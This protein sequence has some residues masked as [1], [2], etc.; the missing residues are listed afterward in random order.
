MQTR[1]AIQLSLLRALVIASGLLGSL[2]ASADPV[3]APARGERFPMW[4]GLA[5]GGVGLAGVGIGIG[6]AIEAKVA[7]DEARL[8]RDEL[9]RRD[10]CL[11]P[12]P[13]D[14]CILIQNKLETHDLLGTGSIVAFAV[15][16]ALLATGVALFAVSV[17]S[18]QHADQEKAPVTAVA[19]WFT[20]DAGG[21][22]VG[23][24]F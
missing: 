13:P 12:F 16:G 8:W 20:S 14:E 4:P 24:S 2:S 9:P 18:D 3:E 22:V 6:F 17:T 7:A 10:S 23:G 19:P 5:V 15:G 21:L 1:S 11:M